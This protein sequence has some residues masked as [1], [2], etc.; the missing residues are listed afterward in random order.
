MDRYGYVERFRRDETDEPGEV[1]LTE[2]RAIARLIRLP[3][4]FMCDVTGGP[5]EGWSLPGPFITLRTAPPLPI[6]QR[7]YKE[8]LARHELYDP[9]TDE[10]ALYQKFAN[11]T[12]WSK[13]WGTADLHGLGAFE[14]DAVPFHLGAITARDAG[15]R[16]V[17]E[18]T[19]EEHR[20]ALQREIGQALHFVQRYG[21]L[22]LPEDYR[23]YDGGTP[24]P[25]EPVFSILLESRRLR[26]VLEMH[27]ALRSYPSDGGNRLRDALELLAYHQ[28]LYW[29]ETRP[30]VPRWDE[31]V[32]FARDFIQTRLNDYLQGTY[33][34]SARGCITLVTIGVD[35]SLTQGLGFHNLLEAVYL[36]AA[37]ALTTRT[38]FHTCPNCGVLF[39]TTRKNKRYCSD[40][41]GNAARVRASR[42]S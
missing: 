7:A 20:Q 23:G 42:A 34:R 19:E 28:V 21:P 31:A 8:W 24:P 33:A 30:P 10:P 17:R 37:R 38:A 2:H 41:C 1:R 26:E 25:G 5:R 14:R 39:E 11:L 32:D 22:G 4:A 40:A 3:E 16:R 18:P 13:D 9:L 35:G 36:Q 15:V 12:S 27:T 29:Y 6:Y